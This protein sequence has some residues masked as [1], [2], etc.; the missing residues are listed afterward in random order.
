MNMS[1][2]QLFLNNL[3][4]IIPEVILLAG[5][6]F[7]LLFDLFVKDKT[8]VCTFLLSCGV[9]ILAFVYMIFEH[10]LLHPIAF[11]GQ[12][13]CDGFSIFIKAVCCVC[14]FVT[15]IY[16][17]R[18]WC[19]KKDIDGVKN[20]FYVLSLLSLLGGF[21]MISAG[22]L[23][24]LYLGL[25][26]L[27]LPLYAM[28]ALETK[29]IRSSEAALKYFVMGA[30]ASG[31]LLYGMSL[32]FGM[33][34]TLD[35]KGIVDAFMDLNQMPI[36]DQTVILCGFGFLVVAIAFKFGLVPFHMWVPDVYQGAPTPVT[37]IIGS[38]TKLAAF[39]FLIRLF[40][41]ALGSL[42]P[43]WQVLF[44]ILGLLSVIIGNFGAL[45]QTNLKRIF[46]Y[47]TIGHMGFLFLGLSC[48]DTFGYESAIF[49]ITS[50]GIA[51]V[52]G[53]GVILLL[54]YKSGRG[55]ELSDYTGLNRRHPWI[56]FL[57]MLF[58][59]SFAGIPPF[60]GF[61]AKL[62]VLDAMLKTGSNI[63]YVSAII[64]L[65][66]SV[67][68]AFYYVRIIKHMYFDH[69]NPLEPDD[70]LEPKHSVVG[71]DSLVLTVNGLFVFFIG[72]FPWAWVEMSH[73]AALS[74]G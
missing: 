62:F 45:L 14:L 63:Y 3:W 65:F 17:R 1:I 7:I 71:F 4:A 30:L 27:S 48:A 13:Y 19:A 21:V 34:H 29:N 37:A 67:V 54:Q 46:A 26:L 11:G 47:S 44:L 38:V 20:E 55:A 60:I 39:G 8:K 2:G 32:I 18:Y 40:V 68:A 28:I 16:S 73:Y 74:L 70:M 49:Y 53:F 5:S 15:F 51:S 43:H 6:C 41:Y 33:A 22:S 42:K 25:E 36:F 64:A 10:P 50:Y 59:F 52:G 31:I 69:S 72:V 35:L 57:M 66:M 9:L 56:A 24:V 12:Y 23:L 58:L 61:D